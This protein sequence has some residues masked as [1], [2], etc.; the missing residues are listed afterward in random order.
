M[1]SKYE[2][3]IRKAETLKFENNR[4]HCYALIKSTQLYYSYYYQAKQ[5]SMIKKKLSFLYDK[6]G[7]I[8]KNE[9]GIMTLLGLEFYRRLQ[10]C[11]YDSPVSPK[12]LCDDIYNWRSEIPDLIKELDLGDIKFGKMKIGEYLSDCC[13][14]ASKYLNGKNR[15]N[16]KQSSIKNAIEIYDKYNE[17]VLLDEK[18]SFDEVLS[19]EYINL[20]LEV[21]EQQ[22]AFLGMNITPI[23]T[24]LC[25]ETVGGKE[26]DSGTWEWCFNISFSKRLSTIKENIDNIKGLG[27]TFNYYKAFS[28]K[29]DAVIEKIN[30]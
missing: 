23:L 5:L 1:T 25:E 15:I 17:F 3:F 6:N 9:L 16:L 19:E 27:K 2:C 28:K 29:M 10:E 11:R 20:L 7:K 12:A 24:L 21:M 18:K 22:E 13:R 26:M 4:I 30:E 8:K 14:K